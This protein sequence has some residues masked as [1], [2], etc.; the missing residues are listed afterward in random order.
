MNN[1]F[2]YTMDSRIVWFSDQAFQVPV[3][4]DLYRVYQIENL[5]SEVRLDNC[6]DYIVKDFLKFNQREVFHSPCLN[7]DREIWTLRN[8]KIKIFW[9]LCSLINLA[10]D[11]SLPPLKIS[12]NE[13]IELVSGSLPDFEKLDAETQKKHSEFVEQ[14]LHQKLTEFKNKYFFYVQK[15]QAAQTI[16]EV[17]NLSLEINFNRINII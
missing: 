6:F 1:Q 10:I 16:L 13:K 11:L 17:K 4:D 2:I 3:L 9:Q 7:L 5:D 15:I 14:L 12:V 8:E